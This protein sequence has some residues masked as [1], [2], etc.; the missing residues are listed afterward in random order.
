MLKERTNKRLVIG[1]PILVLDTKTD[2]K[3][4]FLSFSEAA[5]YFDTYP[6]TIWR[7]VHNDKL[8][9]NRYKINVINDLQ[10]NFKVYKMYGKTS[11]KI[12]FFSK[13]FIYI[14]LAYKWIIYNYFLIFYVLL[15]LLFLTI[16]LMSIQYI[17]YIYIDIYGDYISIMHNIKINH[18][19]V[20]LHYDLNPKS[21]LLST[22]PRGKISRFIEVDYSW[23]ISA[24]LSIYQ[25][26]INEV[27]L[28]FSSG[29]NVSMMNSINSVNSSPIIERIDLNSVFNTMVINTA[30]IIESMDNNS[31][32]INSNRNSLTLNTSIDL[33]GGQYRNKELLNYQ[34]NILYLLINNLSPSIY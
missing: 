17:V 6:K 30:P 5:R 11:N 21:G 8:Y 33:L 14:K 15:S 29:A 32:S 7:I 20:M 13:F 3:I 23:F 1:T 9:L 26:I 12:L 25:P 22:S 2:K 16:F 24:K 31:L 10:C 19:N 34:S 18:F 4:K 27:N 28:D